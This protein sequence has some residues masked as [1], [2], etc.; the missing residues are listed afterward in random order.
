MRDSPSITSIHSSCLTW[1]VQVPFCVVFTKVDKR[2]KRCP[3]PR[4]NMTAFQVRLI[5]AP[6]GLMKPLA[7]SLLERQTA[8]LLSAWH[9]GIQSLSMHTALFMYTA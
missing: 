3:L 1:P 9:R 7:L 5:S 4:D 8:A 2:K 6:Q